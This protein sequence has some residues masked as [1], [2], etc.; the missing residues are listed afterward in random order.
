[1]RLES[2]HSTL[3]NADSARGNLWTSDIKRLQPFQQQVYIN[4][5]NKT[6][7]TICNG[8]LHGQD[9][10]LTLVAEPVGIGYHHI[11]KRDGTRVR[12]TVLVSHGRPHQTEEVESGCTNRWPMFCSLRP[13]VIPTESPSTM[14]PV[15]ALPVLSV[16]LHR[17]QAISAARL[18]R[19]IVLVVLA[20]TAGSNAQAAQDLVRAST[21]NQLAW[22]APVIHIFWPLRTQS[23]PFFSAVVCE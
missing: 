23:L 10:A 11:L 9:E 1:M 14:K 17:Q 19:H 18:N 20:G 16:L 2:N 7:G 22:P 13:R 6:C 8:D 12:G 21:K 15:K 4:S 5:N 3:A